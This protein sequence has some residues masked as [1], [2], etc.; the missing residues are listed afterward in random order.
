MEAIRNFHIATPPQGETPDIPA[1]GN[2]NYPPPV[3]QKNGTT[4]PPVDSNE[5]FDHFKSY[6]KVLLYLGSDTFSIRQLAK[7]LMDK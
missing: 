6:N 3:P 1:G 4:L 2:Q 5:G 7:E